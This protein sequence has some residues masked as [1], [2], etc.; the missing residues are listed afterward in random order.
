MNY[1]AGSINAKNR[2]RG[3][4][5]RI[6]MGLSA[7]LC[8][9]TFAAEV[10]LDRPV[11]AGELTVFQSAYEENN[12]YYLPDKPVLATNDRGTPKF[13]FMQYVRGQNEE[14]ITGGGLV[15]AVVKLE[16]TDD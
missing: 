8:G 4:T 2:Y 12:Y 16:V 10:F 6:V 5:A 9:Q 1:R 14:Q 11:R 3:L 13:S 7:V 15:H